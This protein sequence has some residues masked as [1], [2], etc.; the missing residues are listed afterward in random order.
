MTTETNSVVLDSSPHRDKA[1]IRQQYQRIVTS[2]ETYVAKLPLVTTPEITARFKR[3]LA[4][5]MKMADE[6]I[7]EPDETRCIKLLEEIEE[8]LQILEAV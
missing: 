5:T 8:T 2:I 3:E 1:V 7:S 6:A 4:V